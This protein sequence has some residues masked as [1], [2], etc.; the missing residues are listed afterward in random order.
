MPKAF[1]FGE[2]QRAGNSKLPAA[3]CSKNKQN[4]GGKTK[5]SLR[6]FSGIT[7]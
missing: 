2:N 7:R 6:Q 4:L 5:V 1:V 3:I